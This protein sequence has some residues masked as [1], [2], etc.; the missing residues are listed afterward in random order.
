[1]EPPARL[2][3]RATGSV[4]HPLIS[5]RERQQIDA[6]NASG[7]TPAVFIHGLWL[8]AGSWQPWEQMFEQSG[9]APVAVDWPDDP[10]TVEQARARPEVLAGK[11]VGQVA[12][13]VS[14]V[15]AAL[16]AKPVVVGHS[17]GGLFAQI[18]AGRGESVASVA[19][20][21]APFRGVLALPVSTLRSAMPVLANPA[22]RK[23]A[24]SLTLP[25]FRYG[26][27]NAVSEGEARQLHE[28]FHVPAPGAPLFEGAFANLNPG[29]KVKV[30]TRNPQR[31]PLLLISGGA[32]HTVPHAITKGSFNKQKRNSNPTEFTEVPNR[33]HSL[34]IDSGWQEVAGRALE[35]VKRFPAS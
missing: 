17:F 10:E 32:D 15:V 1:M 8:L 30:D 34:T 6:A 13:H 31:G 23:R 18:S 20:D 27:A 28:T 2:V 29:T 33:G 7:R 22:N 4:Q 14:E 35:F 19:I 3:K 9:Y 25:Q 5:A 12:G 11:T 24:I 26:W 16:S 21:P